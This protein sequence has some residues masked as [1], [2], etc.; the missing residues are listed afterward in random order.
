MEPQFRLVAN[1]RFSRKLMGMLRYAT[2]VTVLH[3]GIPWVS[4]GPWVF[5]LSFGLDSMCV[6]MP[7]VMEPAPQIRG[8]KSIPAIFHTE[9]SG[10]PVPESRQ[11]RVGEVKRLAIQCEVFSTT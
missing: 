7:A 3:H 2:S 10:P 4:V 11:S 8:T 6:R 1:L 5:R 9:R